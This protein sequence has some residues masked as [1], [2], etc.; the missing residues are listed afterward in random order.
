MADRS[1]VQTNNFRLSTKIRDGGEGVWL[2]PDDVSDGMAACRDRSLTRPD[3]QGW[4]PMTSI[5]CWPV[6]PQDVLDSQAL[7][8]GGDHERTATHDTYRHSHAKR[9][10]LPRRVCHG[11]DAAYRKSPVLLIESPSLV[12]LQVSGCCWL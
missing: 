10:L 11:G 3:S 5:L 1:L 8:G 6:T 4:G 9:A 7:A 2:A 12:V